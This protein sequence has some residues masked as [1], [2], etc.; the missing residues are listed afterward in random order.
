MATRGYAV[1]LT[2]ISNCR[3]K[4]PPLKTSPLPAAGAALL[5]LPELAALVAD[6]SAEGAAALD[7]VA[8]AVAVGSLEG[9]CAAAA[10]VVDS[11]SEAGAGTAPGDAATV[12]LL[13]SGCGG[14]A[15]LAA[16]ASLVAEGVQ[17]EQV[18]AQ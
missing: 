6:V 11:C 18:A 17:R 15:G 7:W 16:V 5:L 12:L 4:H 2:C 9:A 8:A 3:Q 14:M 1:H 10:A 13:G